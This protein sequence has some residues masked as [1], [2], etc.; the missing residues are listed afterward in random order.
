[1]GTFYVGKGI[2]KSVCF[3]EW[4]LGV[5][6]ISQSQAGEKSK[7]EKLRVIFFC[8]ITRVQKGS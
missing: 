8:Q 5:V 6:A 3:F 2:G 7:G 1:V 4:L